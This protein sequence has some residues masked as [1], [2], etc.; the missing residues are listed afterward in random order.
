MT[1]PPIPVL[2]NNRDLHPGSI[3]EQC[4]RLDQAEVYLIDNGS[5]F[6]AT[7]NYLEWPP[8]PEAIRI[9]YR[10]TNG[11]ALCSRARH[12]ALLEPSE[13][14]NGGPRSACWLVGMERWGWLQ[15]GI[16]YYATTDSDLDLSRIPRD[17]LTLFASM[18]E[19]H[20]ELVKVGCALSLADLPD[21]PAAIRAFRSEADYWANDVTSWHRPI[22]APIYAAPIDT[23]FAVYRLDPPWD[24]AY[25]PAWRVAGHYTARHLPW[26]HTD[27]D[28]PADYRWYLDHADPQGTVYT[29]AEIARRNVSHA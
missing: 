22:G 2:I 24:G 9:A 5:T 12:T 15:R 21:T 17:A 8:N 20:P 11:G 27:D 1:L 18:L 29:A 26:H 19:E 13:I 7:R 10:G 25:A 16:R 4:Q 6:P 3:V 28:R 23:T 14:L